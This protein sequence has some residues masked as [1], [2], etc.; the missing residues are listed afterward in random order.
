MTSSIWR[1]WQRARIARLP[2]RFPATPLGEKERRLPSARHG[3]A[4][5]ERFETR[6]RRCAVERGC[7]EDRQ[8][9]ATSVLRARPLDQA[10]PP[11]RRLGPRS[12]R[13]D[14][15]D[16]PGCGPA[17]RPMALVPGTHRGRRL[18]RSPPVRREVGTVRRSSRS[19][20]TRCASGPELAQS[21]AQVCL[22]PSSAS[23]IECR[24]LKRRG[25]SG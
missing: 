4:R 20:C 24:G 3:S 14:A 13:R 16:K 10:G 22:V 1:G 18:E 21:D 12:F 23:V 8:L 2:K 9:R 19:S 5:E 25:A 17:F 6:R 15:S 11:R 7:R